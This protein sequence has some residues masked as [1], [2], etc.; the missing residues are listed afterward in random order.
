MTHIYFEALKDNVE[1]LKDNG[2]L[3]VQFEIRLI[4][5]DL[6]NKLHVKD[7]TVV[8]M[9]VRKWVLFSVIRSIISQTM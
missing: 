6:K 9:G 8:I 4:S 7:D 1:A 2:G 5:Q 3:E